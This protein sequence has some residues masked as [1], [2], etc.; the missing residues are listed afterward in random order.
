MEEELL[1]IISVMEKNG[2]SPE[3]IA[4]VVKAYDE[5]NA[6]KTITPLKKKRN[7]TIKYRKHEIGFF[8]KEGIYFFGFRRNN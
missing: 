8:Y 6:N 3:S 7:Y 5:K 2:E 4:E 1:Q